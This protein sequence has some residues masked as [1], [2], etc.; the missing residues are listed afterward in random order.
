MS[1]EQIFDICDSLIDQ[2]TAL[3]GYIQL[4]KMSNKVDYSIVILDQVNNLEEIIDQLV[5]HLITLN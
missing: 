3:K 1:N 2:L 5:K 4:N